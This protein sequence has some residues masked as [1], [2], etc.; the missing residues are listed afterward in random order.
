LN[1]AWILWVEGNKVLKVIFETVAL[2]SKKCDAKVVRVGGNGE[3]CMRWI[4]T[5]VDNHF[6]VMSK[7]ELI[8]KVTNT[9]AHN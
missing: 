6:T 8:F 9:Q 5:N 3:S 2:Q 7:I 1:G 4:G